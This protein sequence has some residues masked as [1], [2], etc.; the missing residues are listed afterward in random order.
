MRIGFNARGQL[1]GVNVYFTVEKIACA[2]WPT[3]WVRVTS[4]EFNG[5]GDPADIAQTG[6]I[7]Y[8]AY[9]MDSPDDV[10]FIGRIVLDD[11][12]NMTLL[13]KFQQGLVWL[14]KEPDLNKE[15]EYTIDTDEEYGGLFTPNGA[16][17]LSLPITN[18]QP[19]DG[20][21]L[22]TECTVNGSWVSGS[23]RMWTLHVHD[24]THPGHAEDWVAAGVFAAESAFPRQITLE[25]IDGGL[26]AVFDR[27]VAAR[28]VD[29]EPALTVFTDFA[30]SENQLIMY[31]FNN[32]A[33]WGATGGSA[34]VRSMEVLDN[35][36]RVFT[37]EVYT[38]ELDHDYEP[39]KRLELLG[40]INHRYEPEESGDV[41]IE[42]TVKITAPRYGF[43]PC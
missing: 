37:V 12:G 35:G 1:P 24:L 11:S 25:Y 28:V 27:N 30:D 32:G 36:D 7:E 26:V 6:P 20:D 39:P 14:P 42:F 17:E 43:K 3:A 33:L 10:M 21:K 29:K 5:C 15:F 40:P 13:I 31:W 34:S 38:K 2:G 18:R 8:I 41:Y 4:A 9:T 22:C 16:I 23:D 19:E